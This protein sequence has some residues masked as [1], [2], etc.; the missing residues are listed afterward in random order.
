MKKVG[1]ILTA[2]IF[3]LLN[4]ESVLGC[5]CVPATI[6]QK[7]EQAQSVF[8]GRVVG[9]TATQIRFKV[10]KTWKGALYSEI[11][12]YAGNKVITSCD[13]S[14]K[15]GEI[16]LVYAS[17]SSPGNKL[18]TNQC[19]GTKELASAADDLK[20]LGKGKPPPRRKMSRIHKRR[21]H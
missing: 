5:V 8:A 14:F 12:L 15:N 2:G 13:V 6:P 20:I 16:Y 17:T 10:Q 18:E 1:L 11:S 4:S 21:S 7:I 3:L 9:R 19:S